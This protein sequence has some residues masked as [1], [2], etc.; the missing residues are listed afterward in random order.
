MKMLKGMFHLYCHKTKYAGGYCTD[1]L[2][3]ITTGLS[4]V[5]QDHVAVVQTTWLLG[6]FITLLVEFFALT[7][8]EYTREGNAFIHPNL[9]AL[10]MLLRLK[11]L[12]MS[13]AIEP[14]KSPHSFHMEMLCSKLF[15][16]DRGKKKRK[17][18]KMHWDFYK[19]ML[20]TVYSSD[21]FE[22]TVMTQYL[23]FVI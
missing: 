5:Q 1:C 23:N 3:T 13:D 14:V 4:M 18:F 7:V 20:Y 21:N 11:I 17:L 15:T 2:F 6:L 8:Y 22:W 10:V 19:D 9:Q 16:R 12:F